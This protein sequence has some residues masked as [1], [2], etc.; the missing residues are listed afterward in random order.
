MSRRDSQ[1]D[2]LDSIQ[3]SFDDY[4]KNAQ[5]SPFPEE[6]PLT[7]QVE[8][9]LYSTDDHSTKISNIA[10]A[11]LENLR[12][13]IDGEAVDIALAQAL[14]HHL[15]A[16]IECSK[17]DVKNSF[18][19]V[20]DAYFDK[21]EQIPENRLKTFE[22]FLTLVRA[23]VPRTDDNKD[24]RNALKTK[25]LTVKAMRGID[26]DTGNT[27]DDTGSISTLNSDAIHERNEIAAH[28]ALDNLYETSKGY[29][30]SGVSLSSIWSSVK[31]AT[32][33]DKTLQDS[34]DAADDIRS[35]YESMRDN[36]TKVNEAVCTASAYI[37]DIYAKNQKAGL[38][39]DCIAKNLPALARV[40][41]TNSIESLHGYLKGAFS[42]LNHSENTFTDSNIKKLI[43]LYLKVRGI[44]I[45]KQQANIEAKIHN[46]VFSRLENNADLSIFGEKSMLMTNEEGLNL[47]HKLAVSESDQSARLERLQAEHPE[48]FDRLL[49]KQNNDRNKPLAV[50]LA[51][52]TDPDA[53]IL[54]VHPENFAFLAKAQAGF[55]G[56]TFD[57][58]RIAVDSLV[59]VINTLLEAETE[60]GSHQEYIDRLLTSVEPSMALDIVKL[61]IKK[62]PTSKDSD[63]FV[64]SL[65][66]IRNKYLAEEETNIFQARQIVSNNQ[67]MV[68]VN[69]IL[70]SML[71]L[72]CSMKIT[73]PIFTHPYLLM[74]FQ[75]LKT[76]ASQ[77]SGSLIGEI[78]TLVYEKFIPTLTE[79][80]YSAEDINQILPY[81]NEIPT[82]EDPTL[83]EQLEAIKT[84]C[85]ERKAMLSIQG[86]GPIDQSNF[87]VYLSIPLEDK[88]AKVK[89]LAEQYLSDATRWSHK[90]TQATVLYEADSAEALLD[91]ACVNYL[92]ALFA[93]DTQALPLGKKFDRM[94]LPAVIGLLACQDR[95]ENISHA[96]KTRI[97]ICQILQVALANKALVKA[98]KILL[99]ELVQHTLEAL[100]HHAENH[101]S[102]KGSNSI[103]ARSNQLSSFVLYAY[104]NNTDPDITQALEKL[105]IEKCFTSALLIGQHHK[106]RSF[107]DE[108]KDVILLQVRRIFTCSSSDINIILKTLCQQA[109]PF[110]IENETLHRTNHE[111]LKLIN[112]MRAIYAFH[113]DEYKTLLTTE[114]EN[115]KTPIEHLAHHEFYTLHEDFD[116]ESSALFN[117]ALEMLLPD[118]AHFP[119]LIPV[120]KKLVENEY[121]HGTLIKCLCDRYP[122]YANNIA[123]N[124]LTLENSNMHNLAYLLL[125][126]CET[127][128]E[129]QLLA[130][131]VFM[132]CL[133]LPV[134]FETKVAIID[135][136]SRGMHMG[137]SFF[138]THLK[139]ALIALDKT[140]KDDPSFEPSD[141]DKLVI[142][143][144]K[145]PGINLRKAGD[146]A[147][148]NE[149]S[150]STTGVDG[151]ASIWG[152]R[153]TGS[154][155]SSDSDKDKDKTLTD[156]EAFGL[157]EGGR[158]DR[159]GNGGL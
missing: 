58:Y 74:G 95:P 111:I 120:I 5:P 144:A 113:P 26:S 10:F 132:Q 54:S 136:L 90:K 134:E 150:A 108:F 45:S 105:L 22:D 98:K 94:I 156:T 70:V 130:D 59:D 93:T 154:V 151:H 43:T 36:E 41:N 147:Q 73:A 82:P 18:Y 15:P 78:I 34:Y 62:N 61:L 75:I 138:R 25:I 9:I 92:R 47:L 30:T 101:S 19:R 104:F 33:T 141:Y 109:L 139:E 37:Y 55:N 69:K 99:I 91:S 124:E 112:C 11:I 83:R 84:E 4:L 89:K 29:K 135:S 102:R 86:D 79:G 2:L 87:A 126:Q 32:G 52:I 110:N 143:C 148:F 122:G 44:F 72:R 28:A 60:E 127:Q 51:T 88:A 40:A 158:D 159:L 50:C 66:T 7:T 24:A 65:W 118:D 76:D 64:R 57:D 80:D 142:A 71:E 103:Y 115:R 56:E 107:R 133:N 46:I 31:Q 100:T 1:T 67:T 128:L 14:I 35:I 81:L 42:L 152:E 53:S 49:E 157:V 153:S 125:A 8:Q 13:Y 12:A 131:V 106:N 63:S 27:S 140:I 114:D 21:R 155:E 116:T 20:A 38:F 85:A 123:F 39:F 97:R 96:N 68:D 121:D 16:L 119:E 117:K 146:Y 77:D 23:S 145:L 3:A 17:D 129:D 48:S 137:P 149:L 6:N